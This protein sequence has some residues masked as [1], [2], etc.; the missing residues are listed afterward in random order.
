MNVR[1]GVPLCVYDSFREN[2]IHMHVKIDKVQIKIYEQ[3]GWP[4]VAGTKNII[5]E[6]LSWYKP[7]TFSNDFFASITF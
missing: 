1:M 4:F 6:I 3:I 2:G 5:Y 7:H